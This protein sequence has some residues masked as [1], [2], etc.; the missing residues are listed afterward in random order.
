M[1]FQLSL[2]EN[3][4]NSSVNPTW[5]PSDDVKMTEIGL[6]DQDKDLLAV[7]KLKRPVLR[8]GSQ[9]FTVKVD[10]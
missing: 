1:K 4:F 8:T 6:Y 9:V 10:F 2:N 7:G 5:I 3:Q